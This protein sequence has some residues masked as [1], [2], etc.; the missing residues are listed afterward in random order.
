MEKAAALAK[1]NRWVC[2]FSSPPALLGVGL[3]HK[4]QTFVFHCHGCFVGSNSRSC[5]DLVELIQKAPGAPG[6]W[7]VVVCASHVL[8]IF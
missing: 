8:L 4:T 3:I 7:S 6:C 1:E 2:L 5:Y